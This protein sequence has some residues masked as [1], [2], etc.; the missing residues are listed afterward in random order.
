MYI[1]YKSCNLNCYYKNVASFK[2]LSNCK[3]EALVLKY[4]M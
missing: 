3:Y 1:F 4:K 2:Y